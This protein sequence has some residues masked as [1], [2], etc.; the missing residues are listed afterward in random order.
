MDRGLKT[1]LSIGSI[2]KLCSICSIFGEKSYTE[3]IY[4][5]VIKRGVK[6]TTKMFTRSILYMLF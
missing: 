3:K 5:I 1:I 2:K 4:I 6:N